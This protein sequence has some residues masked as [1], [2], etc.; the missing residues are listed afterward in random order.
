MMLMP[1]LYVLSLEAQNASYGQ[2]G[3]LASLIRQTSKLRA[4]RVLVDSIQ[5]PADASAFIGAIYAGAQGSIATLSALTA[6]EGIE[7]LQRLVSADNVTA[8]MAKVVGAID[9]VVSLRAF[10]DATRRIVDI[11]EVV[12]DENGNVALV[13]VFVWEDAGM[14]TGQFK[15]TGNV[16]AFYRALQRGGVSLDP[17][18]F[19][20]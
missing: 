15:A 14:G 13:T 17:S 10:S 4:E 18:I 19:N 20:V 12:S 9:I 2:G 3:D 5:T 6:A 1:Q 16:P 7:N 8:G 11:S